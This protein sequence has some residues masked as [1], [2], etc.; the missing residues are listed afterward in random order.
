MPGVHCE[1][2]K[3]C[4][5]KVKNMH[6]VHGCM[7]GFLTNLPWLQ[8]DTCK[9]TTTM[10]RVARRMLLPRLPDPLMRL[11]LHHLEGFVHRNLATT[12]QNGAAFGHLGSRVQRIRLNNGV[13]AG[14][15]PHGAITNGSVARDAFGLT[16]KR[17]APIDDVT[18]ELTVPGSPRLQDCGLFGFSLGHTATGI[19]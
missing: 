4:V 13:P 19:E 12:L 8:V 1:Q 9:P 6:K 17:I 5:N 3:L 18:A 15:R 10:G 2:E 7:P 16:G 11:C 14:H